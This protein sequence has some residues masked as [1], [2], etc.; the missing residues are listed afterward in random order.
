MVL[1]ERIIVGCNSKHS[2]SPHSQQVWGMNRGFLFKQLPLMGSSSFPAT[3]LTAR[4]TSLGLPCLS[5]AACVSRIFQ[6]SARPQGSGCDPHPLLRSFFLINMDYWIGCGEDHCIENS[7][8]VNHKMVNVGFFFQTSPLSA[9]ATSTG[10]TKGRHI[11]TTM[12]LPKPAQSGWKHTQGRRRIKN[13][14]WNKKRALCT[15]SPG[16]Y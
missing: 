2:S 5:K 13:Q 10:T 4:R 12:L 1:S 14:G 6:R 8:H 3:G 15:S 7:R 9:L 11:A 16:V